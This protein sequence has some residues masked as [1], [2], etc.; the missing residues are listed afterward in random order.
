M[1]S[2]A[3]QPA[4]VIKLPRFITGDLAFAALRTEAAN[5]T[6][7]T[8]QKLIAGHFPQLYKLLEQDGVPALILKAYDGPMLNQLLDSEEKLDKLAALIKL[9]ASPLSNLRLSNRSWLIDER[10]FDEQLRQ[11]GEKVIQLF[12]QERENLEKAI[13][14]VLTDRSIIGLTLPGCFW[15]REYN[16]WNILVAKPDQRPMVLDWEDAEMAGLPLLDFYNYFTIAFRILLVGETAAAKKRPLANRQQR[17]A[18]LL[19]CYRQELAAYCE[20]LQLNQAVSD[21]CYL[22]YLLD[23]IRFFAAPKRQE[24]TYAASWLPMLKAGVNF[25]RYLKSSLPS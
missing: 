9:G 24:S 2:V 11:P 8:S 23:V 17:I 14:N 10:F 1:I 22:I 21:L 3:G 20:A 13:N 15:H 16:P 4:A 18:T 19:T 7:L 6:E 12:P 5:L 25:E